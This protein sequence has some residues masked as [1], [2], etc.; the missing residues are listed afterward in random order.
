MTLVSRSLAAIAVAVAMLALAPAES[1][2]QNRSFDVS[3]LDGS[4]RLAAEQARAA[5]GRALAAAARSRAQAPGTID[6]VAEGGDRYMGEG[7][8]AGAQ[9]QRNGHGFQ[10]WDDGEFFAGQFQ[11]SQIGGS[12]AGPGVYQ[13]VD[14]R[15][16]EGQ[17]LND[18]RHGYGVQ[19]TP[20]GEVFHAGQWLNGEPVQ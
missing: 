16:Y 11:A 18:L 10:S 3:Q 8:G 15:V 6:F 4:T 14:G 17:W 13:F 12:R 20:T 5:Q 7:Y 19:W 9:A 2:A 1:Y